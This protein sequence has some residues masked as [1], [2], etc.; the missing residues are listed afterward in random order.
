MKKLE[1]TLSNMILSLG[2]ICVVAGSA[3]AAVSHL[4]HDAI[5]LAKSEKL[6]TALSEVVPNFDN[7]PIEEKTKIALNEGDTLLLYPARKGSNLIGAA[8]ESTTN[9]GFNGEVKVLVGID[10][11]GKLINYSVL[12]QKETPGLGTKMVDWFRST[13]KPGQSVIGRDLTQGDLTVAKD[14]GT[15]DAITAATISSRAFLRTI[16]KAYKA[17]TTYQTSLAT[18][19]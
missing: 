3:L 15:V 12:G 8:I 4:T 19:Q 14:R 2:L 18:N 7:N 11:Q 9:S 10:T 16:N 1:S 5:E 13:E 17:F 6:Q